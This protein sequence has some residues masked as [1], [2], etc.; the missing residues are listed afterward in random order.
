MFIVLE[1]I[2]EIV[3]HVYSIVISIQER[4]Q[5]LPIVVIAQDVHDPFLKI[6]FPTNVEKQMVIP[7]VRVV[8]EV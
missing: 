8:D 1:V 6:I 5:V 3:M 4:V 2:V 7:V